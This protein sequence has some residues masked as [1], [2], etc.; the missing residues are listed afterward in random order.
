MN[1]FEPMV[2]RTSDGNE[3]TDSEPPAEAWREEWSRSTAVDAPASLNRVLSVLSHHDRRQALYYLHECGDDASLSRLVRHVVARQ[4]NG[5]LA[6]VPDETFE[7]THRS[8]RETHLPK[9]ALVGLVDYDVEEDWV[10]LSG[11][12]DVV[13]NAFL[14]H[15]LE[16]TASAERPDGTTA[17]DCDAG[18]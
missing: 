3:R 1:D 8:F 10:A 2:T 4:T 11:N 6:S 13:P 7:R 15:L 9:L 16:L 18:R 5:D 12:A 17:V 14:D